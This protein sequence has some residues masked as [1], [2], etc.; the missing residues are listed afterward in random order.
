MVI[1]ALILLTIHFG[2][3]TYYYL[4]NL[5]WARNELKPRRNSNDLPRVSII[6]PT[7]NESNVILSKLDNIYAQDYPRELMELLVIDSGSTDGTAALA[8]K[9]CS[10]H[11]D[12][13]CR[14]INE[15]VRLGKA[16]A[17]NEAL[18]HATG[19]VIVITDADSK[20]LGNSLRRAV[21]LLMSEGVGAVS[22]VKAPITNN[23]IE[24]TYRD[25]YTVLRI[26]ESNRYSTPIFHGELAA[27]RKDLIM[28]FGGFPTDVGADD[29]HM[30]TVLAINGYRALITRDVV[31]QE[32]VPRAVNYHRW[33]L[34]RA[35]HLIQHFIK[36]ITKYGS[37]IPRGFKE[38][39][40][41]EFFLHVINPWVLIAGL[42]LLL[43]AASQGS[44]TAASL[45]G[46]GALLAVV[47][48]LFRTWLYTQFIL[49]AAMIRNMWNREL[50]WEK[51]EKDV[52]Q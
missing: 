19:D 38:I 12:L 43:I 50:V 4:R 23:T 15:G 10:E 39:V 22:C 34:R 44:I 17:L 2:V 52:A 9:W 32:L 3:A 16:H 8:M 31:C 1:I 7:Y 46:L 37:R 29:S 14:V 51:V 5:G 24:S 28:R 20:W 40:Y 26:G 27:F 36:T 45:L 21:E 33:R 49:L 47:V 6:L 25:Y 48:R 13:N 18:K 11:P 42:A 41:T 30:A 35:Q